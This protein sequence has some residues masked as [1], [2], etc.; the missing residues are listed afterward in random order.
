MVSLLLVPVIV[1][2]L[3]LTPLLV[4]R[5]AWC[6]SWLCPSPQV[7]PLLDKGGIHDDN[8]Q[9]TYQT[10]QS[11]FKIL[12]VDPAAYTLGTATPNDAELIAK[13]QTLPYRVVLKIHSLQQGRYGLAIDSVAM[14]VR[15]T[16]QVIP[17]PLRVVDNNPPIYDNNLYQAIYRGQSVGIQLS[18]A[19][20]PVPGGFVTLVP[21]ETD[22]IS[23]EVRSTVVAD[24]HFQAQVTYH[25]I[26]QL[27]S[28]TL[29]LPNLFEI[30]FSDKTNW[31]P[32]QIHNGTLVAAG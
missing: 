10:V 8:L 27:T 5:P 6:P 2:A 18:S 30:V 19:Y 28:H 4:F 22:E 23:L 1:L 14:L 32:Y 21:G 29:T 3:V 24:L 25:V 16:A 20:M 11:S 15:Q 17:Y 26:G 13:D 31:H 9:I 7:K 12:T